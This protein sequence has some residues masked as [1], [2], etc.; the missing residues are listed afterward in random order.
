MG[1]KRATLTFRS[2][3]I[4]T[5]FSM[6]IFFSMQ[7]ASADVV[8]VNAG[9]STNLS[10]STDKHIEGFFFG[11][12][13]GD[14]IIDGSL[15]ETCDDG[16]LISG[17]G[18]SA[19][20]Q[21]ETATPPGGGGGGGSTIN[22]SVIPSEFNLDLNIG[23][24]V[25]KTIQIRNLGSSSVAVSVTQQQLLDRVSFDDTSLTIPAGQ[26]VNLNVVFIAGNETG[27][28]TGKIIIGNKEVLVSLNVQT[29][30]LLFDSNIVVLNP[31]SK[32]SQKD[33]LLTSVTL[34]PLGEPERMDVTLNFAIK[35]Y[36]NKVYLTKSET[37]LVDKQTEIT[38]SFDIG[39]LPLGDY[40]IGLDLI[41][42]NGVAP[43][44]A[45]FKVVEE[46]ARGIFG[47]IV[48]FLVIMILVVAIS[49]IS[50]LV[51]RRLKEKALAKNIS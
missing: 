47:R 18:C 7:T 50:L 29:V 42:P 43:S 34:I 36:L 6:L 41:Y 24:Q 9:G 15:G 28:F 35:D 10:V 25:S 40:V 17:D 22:I 1:I 3:F 12:I 30:P 44:S 46:A 45:Y 33:K 32:V 48:L 5:L 19:I 51:I 14:G 37:L 21:T 23:T 11:G 26:T 8:S 38:R 13:C 2:F 20:C 39:T 49:I 16:N 31:D 4:L 27:F